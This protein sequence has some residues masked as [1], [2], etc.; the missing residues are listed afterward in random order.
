MLMTQSACFID[1]DNIPSP[2][3]SAWGAELEALL[4]SSVRVREA[5]GAGKT[6]SKTLSQWLFTHG[7]EQINAYSPVSGK[8]T[9][10]ILM[11]LAIAEHAFMSAHPMRFILAT[12]DS[13]FAPVLQ[14]LFK[15]GHEVCL[16]TR[17]G[18][19]IDSARNLGIKTITISDPSSSSLSSSSVSSTTSVR[20]KGL[21][22][23]TKSPLR[24]RVIKVCAGLLATQNPM[25]LVNLAHALNPRLGSK[26]Y[27]AM[28]YKKLVLALKDFTPF[29]LTQMENGDYLVGMAHSALVLE[30]IQ[31]ANRLDSEVNFTE[32]TTTELRDD[33]GELMFGQPTLEQLSEILNELYQSPLNGY[34]LPQIHQAFLK[35]Y[36]LFKYAR[37]GHTKFKQFITARLPALTPESEEHHARWFNLT[38][39]LLV[40]G[41]APAEQPVSSDHPQATYQAM[42]AQRELQGMPFE[43][44]SVV[45]QHLC[46]LEHFSALIA[47]GEQ[48]SQQLCLPPEQVKSIMRG[49][50]Q[51][52]LF[53]IQRDEQSSPT[54]HLKG[55]VQ[56]AYLKVK[57]A[58]RALLAP[59]EPLDE[60]S[61]EALWRA[62]AAPT[63]LVASSSR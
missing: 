27:E 13:D 26:W 21:K 43:V 49:L 6:Q 2:K 55:D 57:Q 38:G 46:S 15:L 17:P 41:G 61:W 32:Q 40:L 50:Y 24:A 30:A 23:S 59:F 33:Q 63:P 29:E 10:D 28:G 52:R 60:P 54:Y 3:G 22:K 62:Q 18:H 51:A 14:K 48:I 12:G 11:T 36:P 37:F 19:L 8:N 44:F 1:A 25:K 45:Y 58:L 5:Y 31:E 9:A 56:E 39:A 34:V 53:E 4:D 35:R 16:V 7:F 20:L 47:T 42:L